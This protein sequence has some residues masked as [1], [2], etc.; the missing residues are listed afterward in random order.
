MYLHGCW[1]KLALNSREAKKKYLPKVDI[2]TLFYYVYK[3]VVM[4]KLI[5]DNV[6]FVN[7]IPTKR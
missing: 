7:G 4:I 2:F 3:A 6:I 1:T 5:V